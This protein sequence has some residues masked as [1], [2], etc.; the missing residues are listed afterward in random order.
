MKM[1]EEYSRLGSWNQRIFNYLASTF[2]IKTVAD[3]YKCWQRIDRCVQLYFVRLEM[4]SSPNASVLFFMQM[5]SVNSR[6]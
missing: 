5:G 4:D 2:D 1:S 3:E 6:K